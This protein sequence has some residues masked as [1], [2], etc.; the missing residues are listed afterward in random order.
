MFGVQAP[1]AYARL[2]PQAIAFRPWRGSVTK[3]V[4]A[5]RLVALSLGAVRSGNCGREDDRE[6][7]LKTETGNKRRWA[8][9]APAVTYRFGR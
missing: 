8:T 2:T 4:L 1:G 5:L 7:H 9:E 6:N 3:R